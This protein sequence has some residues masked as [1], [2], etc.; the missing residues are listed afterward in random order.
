V[1]PNFRRLEALT[2]AINKEGPTNELVKQA[3]L[4]L[5]EEVIRLQR[6]VSQLSSIARRAEQQSRL[7]HR[8]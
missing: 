2:R 1:S 8:Y 7:G 3:A 5:I 4:L 6:E